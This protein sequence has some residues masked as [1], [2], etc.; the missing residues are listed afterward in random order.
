MS[1]DN[2]GLNDTSVCFLESSGTLIF[3]D[4]MQKG[5][6]TGITPLVVVLNRIF[7]TSM[8]SHPQTIIKALKF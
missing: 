1:C 3:G 8:L 7:I 2:V 6:L 5:T 4:Q